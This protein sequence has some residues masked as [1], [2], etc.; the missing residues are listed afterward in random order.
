MLPSETSEYNSDRDNDL[1]NRNYTLL[2]SGFEHEFSL[3]AMDFCGYRR[4]IRLR[5]QCAIPVR[6][7]HTT[8]VP[9]SLKRQYLSPRT[10]VLLRVT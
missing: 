6:K 3:D 4:R 5:E 10:E 9:L 7:G 2:R 8:E 1:R